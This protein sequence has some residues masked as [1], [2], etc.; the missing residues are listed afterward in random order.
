MSVKTKHLGRLAG[1]AFMFSN[2]ENEPM[3]VGT[4]AISKDLDPSTNLAGQTVKWW[5]SLSE[6]TY[7]GGT[8]KCD[9]TFDGLRACGWQGANLATVPEQIAAGGLGRDV[10]LTVEHYNGKMKVMWVD[11]PRGAAGGGDMTA[12]QLAELSAKLADRVANLKPKA[13]RMAAKRE[14]PPDDEG[15][16]A[17]YF[18]PPG[19]DYGL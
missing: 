17:D 8:P 16:P 4:F 5:G 11:V 9:G 13:E 2:R 6:G 7:K 18:A 12:Q 10:L 3:F 15:P 14:L 19:D 1:G